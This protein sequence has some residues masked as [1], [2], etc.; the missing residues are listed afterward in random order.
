MRLLI[1]FHTKLVTARTF[2]LV[3]I[4][5]FTDWII[6]SEQSQLYYYWTRISF[7]CTSKHCGFS[8]TQTD[9]IFSLLTE[10][11]SG[12]TFAPNKGLIYLNLQQHLSGSLHDTFSSSQ[13]A[14]ERKQ[15]AVLSPV[16]SPATPHTGSENELEALRL[17]C[18]QLGR[19]VLRLYKPI[20][21]WDSSPR[22][23]INQYS[24]VSMLMTHTFLL[25]FQHSVAVGL[26][27]QAAFDSGLFFRH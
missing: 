6:V 2:I 17:V 22:F 9:L 23:F 16:S 19:R 5:F 8:S 18:D 3:F 21:W 27:P 25:Y 24:T 26:K 14:A 1:Y 4:G 12:K 20:S 7:L 10:H 15:L 11:L 13:S